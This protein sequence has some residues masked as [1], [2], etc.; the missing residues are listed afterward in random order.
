MA[1]LSQGSRSM[2]ERFYADPIIPV[3][4]PILDAHK[5]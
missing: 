4:N 1:E 3:V 2:R 5:L